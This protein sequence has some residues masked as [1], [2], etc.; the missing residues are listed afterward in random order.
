MCGNLKSMAFK[1]W[2]AFGLNSGGVGHFPARN[3][4]FGLRDVLKVE[5]PSPSLSV[6]V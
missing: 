3:L 4:K 2:R 5:C 6:T 1:V